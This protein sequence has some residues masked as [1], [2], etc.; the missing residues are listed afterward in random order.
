MKLAAAMIVTGCGAISFGTAGAKAMA[1]A[2]PTM[3]M[4]NGDAKTA[5]KSRSSI[6]STPSIH[7]CVDRNH[8]RKSFFFSQSA[9]IF[10]TS[11]D[12]G[13]KSY[14]FPTSHHAT[15]KTQTLTPTASNTLTTALVIRS[16]PPLPRS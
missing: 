10:L 3:V 4:T 2:K 11:C 16:N 7:L 6:F 14:N 8:F 12:T 13:R 1:T 5:A 9:T 15:R